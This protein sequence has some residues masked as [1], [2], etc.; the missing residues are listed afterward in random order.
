MEESILKNLPQPIYIYDK[1]NLR[2][3]NANDAALNL[4]GYS[5]D[6][7]LQL[8]LTDLY[9]P[10]DIENLLS[11]PADIKKDE[12]ARELFK[13]RKKDGTYVFVKINKISY[14]YGT[15]EAYLNFL[16]DVS[17][18]FELE[19]N[20]Q[21][22]KAAFDNTNDMIFITDPE[23]IIT[24]INDSVKRNFGE[25]ANNI[26]N[27]SI[28]LLCNEEDKMLINNS[29]FQSH[30]KETVTFTIE[31]KTSAEN[32]IETDIIS[33]PIFNVDNNVDSFVLIAKAVKEYGLNDSGTKKESEA[34][35]KDINVE[36]SR[37]VDSAGKKNS[38]FRGLFHDILTPLN[39]ILGFS[40]ELSE[41]INAPTPEQKEA[42]D[43]IDQNR[44]ALLGLMHSIVEFSD[45]EVDNS[46]TEVTKIPITEIIDIL[47]KDLNEVTG[48]KDLELSYGKISSSLK[49]VTD[50]KKFLNLLINLFRLVGGISKNKKLYFSAY[51]VRKSS[52]N[53]SVSDAFGKSSPQ[54]IETL[55]QLFAG[56]NDPQM[57]G[58]FK[59]NSQIINNLL[60]TLGGQFIEVNENTDKH[61]VA[62]KFPQ[63]LSG[64]I[65][66]PSSPIVED[67]ISISEEE[68]SVIEET[69]ID[70]EQQSFNINEEI[71]IEEEAEMPGSLKEK[72]LVSEIVEQEQEHLPKETK[73]HVDKNEVNL[74]KSQETPANKNGLS[75]LRCLYIED[76][77]DSQILFKVQMKDLK[78]IQF[79]AS[80]E[81]AL[82]LLESNNFDFIIMDI[83]LQGDYNGLDALKVIH[84]LPKFE[85]IPVI[86]VT[87]YVLPGDKEKFIATGFTDFISKP[88]FRDK[89]LESLKKI[90]VN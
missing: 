45:A 81:E 71:E 12:K 57:S 54:L 86:A 55:K 16:Q 20:N 51:P 67:E 66:S 72:E 3:L 29:V 76:Q 77:V 49:I 11:T 84:Q 19:K 2:F 27:T 43:V 5:L 9:A 33:T 56:K 32:R 83:N 4:Y 70:S 47:D 39:V 36:K 75:S 58:I 18:L 1:E 24:Y 40:Q 14:Q 26:L 48:M 13:H 8:D 88:I 38:L 6:E 30:I 25:D 42:I 90:F 41:S 50:K 31:I 74:K 22:F 28:M 7:F 80:F 60:E 82:P 65:E 61:D 64:E 35:E 87:A 69:P 79:A 73:V 10:E 63:K 46:K 37:D 17:E 89:L 23:G 59:L 34:N 52:F 44:T 62:F 21:T 15:S 78:S 53:I 68:E 85:N